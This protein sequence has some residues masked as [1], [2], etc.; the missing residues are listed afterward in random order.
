ME[1]NLLPLCCKNDLEKNLL[2]EL[3]VVASLHQLQSSIFTP[4]SAWN[5]GL[6]NLET[7]HKITVSETLINHF[8]T[9]L[10]TVYFL[11]LPR[12]ALLVLK[13]SLVGCHLVE[14]RLR[15]MRRRS[16]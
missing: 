5:P 1:W 7:N 8:V 15:A 11:E 3:V 14:T 2:N 6:A 13:A 10:G 9:S 16:S 12:S 4:A